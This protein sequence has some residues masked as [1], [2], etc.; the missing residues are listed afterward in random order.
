M[1]IFQIPFPVCYIDFKIAYV[2]SSIV[3]KYNPSNCISLIVVFSK[4]LEFFI[5]LQVNVSSKFDLSSHRSLGLSSKSD[6]FSFIY[7]DGGDV[8]FFLV[9]STT[10]KMDMT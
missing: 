6:I 8:D 4:S 1:G 9:E 10:F 7:L 3:S 5:K 2:I